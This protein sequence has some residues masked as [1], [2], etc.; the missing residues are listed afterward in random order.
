[1]RN[2]VPRIND[3]STFSLLWEY[4]GASQGDRNRMRF[5]CTKCKGVIRDEKP[6]HHYAFDLAEYPCDGI[7]Y[8]EGEE[9]PALVQYKLQLILKAQKEMLEKGAW[10]TKLLEELAELSL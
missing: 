10:I 4:V 6:D 3:N 1:M 7:L 9:K 2:D 8:V 5:Y